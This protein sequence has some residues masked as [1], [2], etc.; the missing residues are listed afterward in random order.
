MLLPAGLQCFPKGET[1]GELVLV[2]GRI[3]TKKELVKAIA[4]ELG[5]PSLVAQKAV[6]NDF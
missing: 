5:I 2:K 4:E 3:V 1:T 6:Q